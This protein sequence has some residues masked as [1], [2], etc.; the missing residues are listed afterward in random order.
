VKL[1]HTERH[2]DPLLL[3]SPEISGKRIPGHDRESCVQP[4]KASLNRV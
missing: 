4:V 1:D 3:L 2:D